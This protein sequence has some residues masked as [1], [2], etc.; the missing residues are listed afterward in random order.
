MGDMTTIEVKACSRTRSGHSADCGVDRMLQGCQ[1]AGR[2][3]VKAHPIARM[4]MLDPG[5]ASLPTNW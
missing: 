5:S 2:L 4:D 1:L 3:V